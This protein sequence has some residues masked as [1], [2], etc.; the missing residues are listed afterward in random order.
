MSNNIDGVFLRFSPLL[1]FFVVL[2]LGLVITGCATPLPE[3]HRYYDRDNLFVSS[4]QIYYYEDVISSEEAVTLYF[5]AR[6]NKSDPDAEI[7]MLT[8]DY[9]DGLKLPPRPIST[10]WLYLGDYYGYQCEWEDISE[11]FRQQCKKVHALIDKDRPYMDIGFTKRSQHQFRGQQAVRAVPG[12]YSF[13][14]VYHRRWAMGFGNA[15]Y[16]FKEVPLL[17]PGS[18]R[19]RFDSGSTSSVSGNLRLWIEKES[20]G[21]VIAELQPSEKISSTKPYITRILDPWPHRVI[22]PGGMRNFPGHN[23]APPPSGP[24]Q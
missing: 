3:H 6:Q 17:E 14:V 7:S 20:D 16:F 1:G 11:S 9:F 18:Y 24:A 23:P 13:R 21:K 8:V 4:D 10:R 5:Q 2:F 12:V 15:Y 22:Q 19:V